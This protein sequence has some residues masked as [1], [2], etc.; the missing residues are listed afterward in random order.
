MKILCIVVVILWFCS[1]R[2]ERNDSCFLSATIW[3]I[4]SIVLSTD[5]RNNTN[6]PIRFGIGSQRSHSLPLWFNL[7]A[8]IR[9]SK[10]LL[11]CVNFLNVYFFNQPQFS[12]LSL[13][14]GEGTYWHLDTYLWV[15]LLSDLVNV[16]FSN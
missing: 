16:Q 14:Y 8:N 2:K 13:R 5:R 12:I 15:I 7:L 10:D 3:T 9:S 4:L 6:Y 11:Q 1:N